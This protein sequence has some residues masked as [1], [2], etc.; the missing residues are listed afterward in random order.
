MIE[1]LHPPFQWA[2]ILLEWEIG[3]AAQ[4]ECGLS[5]AAEP[6]ASAQESGDNYSNGRTMLLIK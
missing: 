6:M 2:V 4:P 1:C 5:S 3:G